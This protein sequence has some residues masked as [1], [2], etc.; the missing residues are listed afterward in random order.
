MKEINLVR[1]NSYLVA[2]NARKL[3]HICYLNEKMA[4]M[5][6]ELAALR[7]KVM[8]EKPSFPLRAL[9]H[10]HQAVGIFVPACFRG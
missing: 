5:E 6:K 7:P 2:D 4:L 8:T 10:R 1:D 3:Q 9:R